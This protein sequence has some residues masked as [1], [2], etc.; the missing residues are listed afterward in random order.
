MA[1]PK[2]IPF[3][4]EQKKRDSEAH[5]GIKFSKKWKENIRLARLGKHHSPETIKKL[6]E[7]FKGSKSSLWRG[8]VSKEDYPYGW[9]ETLKRSIRERDGYICKV[10]GKTQIQE[11]EELERKLSVHHIDY[12]K[13]NCDPKN[14]VTVCHLCHMDT[15]SNREQ[16]IEY[17]NKLKK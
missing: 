5:K 8:G 17:F 16:W 6:S 2:G 4:E 11:T 14:L 3:T 15:N 13:Q 7:A 1:R 9:T 12:D 10:C